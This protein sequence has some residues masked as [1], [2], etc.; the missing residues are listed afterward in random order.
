MGISTVYLF[1]A[2]LGGFPKGL[3]PWLP[4]V[5]HRRGLRGQGKCC[6]NGVLPPQCPPFPVFVCL[7]VRLSQDM[8]DCL[9]WCIRQG[10]AQRGVSVGQC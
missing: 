10:Y 6:G 9:R 1:M 3:L 2:L 5:L 4:R 7:I 8:A